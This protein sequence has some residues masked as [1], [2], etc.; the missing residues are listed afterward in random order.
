MLQD[1]PS[2]ALH[3][4]RER[5]PLLCHREGLAFSPKAPCALTHGANSSRRSSKVIGKTPIWSRY[6]CT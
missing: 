2:M 5:Q 1:V 3:R 6:L 4:R